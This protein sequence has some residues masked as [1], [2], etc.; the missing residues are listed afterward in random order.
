MHA[1]FEGGGRVSARR[2][3]Y[4]FFASP[5][6][7]TQKKG[8][9]AVCDPHA[10]RGGKPASG[11]LRGAP[12]NSLCAARAARTT[13]ASQWTKRVCPSAHPPPRNR[14]GAGAARW[15]GMLDSQQPTANSQQQQPQPH[16]PSL[17]LAPLAQR[18]AIAAAR[19]VQAERSK[20]PCGCPAPSS[21]LCVPRSAGQGVR[22]CAEGH[23]HFVH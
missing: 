18:V 1:W 21:L 2:P 3:R 5:K 7:S 17:R 22:A 13:T 12:W 8:D 11:R 4:L 20:G 19:P 10:E 15:G 16:G 14:H 9:P 6:K 23:T